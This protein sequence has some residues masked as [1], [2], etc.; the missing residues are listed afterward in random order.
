LTW[1]SAEFSA[2]VKPPGFAPSAP[3][4]P[5]APPTDP[6][7][8]TSRRAAFFWRMAL[9]IAITLSVGEIPVMACLPYAAASSRISASR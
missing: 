6:V 8:A 9:R 4:A 5:A 3:P 2:S 1:L 7:W